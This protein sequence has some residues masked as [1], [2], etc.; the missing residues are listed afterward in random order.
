[1]MLR[2]NKIR[3]KVAV[4]FLVACGL[5]D[6]LTIYSS[7]ETLDVLLRA[8]QGLTVTMEELLAADSRA[9]LVAIVS[10][11]AIIGAIISF[12]MWF[13]RGYFNLHT[14]IDNLKYTEGWAAGAWFVPILNLWRPVEIMS[15]MSNRTHELLEQHGLKGPKNNL[16]WI[17]PVWW[18]LWIGTGIMSR[19][20]MRSAFDPNPTLEQ[21]IFTHRIDVYTSAV[22][23]VLTAAAVAMVLIYSKMEDELVHV[24]DLASP[25]TAPRLTD[26]DLLDS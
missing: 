18:T 9:V 21:M 5:C 19:V 17:V 16:K 22:S 11:A 20:G 2:P 26:S 1:M 3:A 4:A 23:I 24:E 15:E 25:G 12:I 13:R 8:Q 6:I 10:L 14:K 7:S